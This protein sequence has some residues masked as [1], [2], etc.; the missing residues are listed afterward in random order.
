MGCYS[1]KLIIKETWIKFLLSLQLCPMHLARCTKLTQTQQLDNN[2][3]QP[4]TGLLYRPEMA[5]DPDA[6]SI[7][8]SFSGIGTE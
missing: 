1:N 6:I 4:T 5:Q 8:L 2:I 7:L 3:I